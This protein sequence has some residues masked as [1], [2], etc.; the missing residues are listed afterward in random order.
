LSDKRKKILLPIVVLAVGGALTVVMINSRAPVA[1]RPPQDF[2][3]LVRVHEVSPEAHRFTIRT[4][5]TV[6]PRT[7]SEIVAEVR[8]Q[9]KE[10]APKFASGGFFE[11]G[12]VMLR[13]D[14]V[15]YELAVVNARSAVAQAEVNAELE[16]ARAEVAR[17]E[18]KDL[19]DGSNARLATRELQVE[20]AHAALEAARARLRQA[21]RDLA[22]TNVRAPYACRIRQKTVDV[23]RYVT[24]GT[25]VAVI[26][27]ID[28]VE[29]R[30]PIPDTDLAFVDVPV[31]YRGERDE[32]PGPTVRLRAEF[33]GQRREWTGRI[34]RVEGEIDPSSRMVN[35]VAQVD[36]P[37]GKV[38]GRTVLPVGL[39]VEAEITGVEIP[40]AF[41]LPRTALRNGDQVLVID[42]ES[43][44]RFRTVEVLRTTRESVV[45]A[46]G[47][48][49]GELVC[50]ST[51]EAVTDG[52][53]VRTGNETREEEKPTPEAVS[54]GAEAGGSR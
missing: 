29:I 51:L 20:Q 19:G 4:H 17:E 44:L 3:P 8:G 24:P 23:G 22:R 18:W 50:T 49:E 53:R 16:E 13:I 11:K 40:D 33:A 5:G 21:E 7:E 28:Y 43:R 15:D 35:L 25:P 31:D 9:V 39:F 54:A 52:M 45:I 30:L 6:A 37:Y 41:V 34:V 14:P 27:A 26:Y 1:T 46:E 32:H 36:D 10:I 38:E 12:E 48:S 42:A 47:L 2:A